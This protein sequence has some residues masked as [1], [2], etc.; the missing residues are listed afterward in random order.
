MDNAEKLRVVIEE[1]QKVRDAYRNMASTRIPETIKEALEGGWE[2]EVKGFDFEIPDSIFY[3]SGQQKKDGS[4]VISVRRAVE[5]LGR[6]QEEF[7]LS[8]TR[9]PL[10]IWKRK[11]ERWRAIIGFFFEHGEEVAGGVKEAAEGLYSALRRV[12]WGRDW[13]GVLGE[14]EAALAVALAAVIA[15]VAAGVVSLALALVV[16]ASEAAGPAV[17]LAMVAEVAAQ[18]SRTQERLRK[19]AFPQGVGLRYWRRKETL[20]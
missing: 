18:K 4:R 5:E 17:W 1:A 2:I 8:L 14:L 20:T 19:G 15:A 12:D 11:L 9:N 3:S 16:S 7:V 10:K 6:L 13:G